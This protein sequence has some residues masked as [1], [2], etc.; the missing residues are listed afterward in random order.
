MSRDRWQAMQDCLTSRKAVL[1]PTTS[2]DFRAPMS[3]VHWAEPMYLRPSSPPKPGRF[4]M[5]IRADSMDFS[6]SSVASGRF[7]R[8]MASCMTPKRTPISAM[9]TSRP[10]KATSMRRNRSPSLS[11]SSSQLS[12]GGLRWAAR[13]NARGGYPRPACAASSWGSRLKFRDS[14]PAGNCPRAVDAGRSLGAC[15]LFVAQPNQMTRAKP[16]VRRR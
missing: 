11:A 8:P 6:A 15:G 10:R 2:P 4:S 1:D 14:P 5:A 12:D 7:P 13:P 16:K 9:W 3:A